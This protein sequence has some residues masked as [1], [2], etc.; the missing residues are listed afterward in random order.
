MSDNK[1]I[2]SNHNARLESLVEQVKTLP[3]ADSGIVPTGTVQIM[4][5]GTYD[6][7]NYANADVAVPVGVFPEGTL[8]VSKNGTYDITS[9]AAVNVNVAG[10]GGG[11][12]VETCTVT[13]YDTIEF[14]G[15]GVYYM[16]G[17]LQ[18]QELYN[19]DN[20]QIV[21]LKNSYFVTFGWGI[22]ASTSPNIIN[23]IDW[24][25]IVVYKVIGDAE[26][27]F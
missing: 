20:K 18:P 7:T 19:V 24:Q 6:V 25:A 2:L 27:G 1:T 12:A 9:F 13:F 15:C 23:I 3:D 16:D 10:S 17:S 22:E 11:G 14:G 26:I 8:D 5:N 21:M 4:A